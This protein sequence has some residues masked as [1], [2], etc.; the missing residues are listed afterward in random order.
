MAGLVGYKGTLSLYGI[1][2]A[3]LTDLDVSAT[4]EDHDTSDLGDY[5]VQHAGGRLKVLVTGNANYLTKTTALHKRILSAVVANIN[6][7]GAI[8]VTDPKGTIALSGNCV[9]LDGGFNMPAG[10][11]VQPFR[12]GMV[13]I[14][15]P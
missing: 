14:T 12:A 5:G 9:W 1:S 15:T 11:M 2:V 10:P 4:R 8:T 3:E 7:T 13:A 6:A